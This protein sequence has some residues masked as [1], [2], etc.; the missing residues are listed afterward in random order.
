MG[1]V[2]VFSQIRYWAAVVIT[3]IFTVFP[4][5]GDILV[6]FIWGGFSVTLLTVKF[7]FVLHFILPWLGAVIVILHLVF[8]HETGRSSVL[9]CHGDYDK[10]MF[11]PYFWLKD[12]INVLVLVVFFVWLILSPF[13]LGEPEIFM[14]VDILSRPAHI[15]PE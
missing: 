11:F 7:F 9:G 15:A 10:I 3:S 13:D 12:M 2:L 4:V 14:D 8:L 1:Y 6:E 5:F